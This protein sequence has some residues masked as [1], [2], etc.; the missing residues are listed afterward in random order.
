MSGEF[1]D[2]LGSEEKEEWPILTDESWEKIEAPAQEK[3][4]QE[5]TQYQKICEAYDRI[6]KRA[7]EKK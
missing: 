4:Y 6:K 7:S 1:D 2:I 3:I 5:K